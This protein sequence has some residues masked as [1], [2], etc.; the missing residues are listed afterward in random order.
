M[1]CVSTDNE[2]QRIPPSV[3]GTQ[4]ILQEGALPLL[5]AAEAAGLHG[6]AK[7][8]LK[9]LLRASI[10]GRLESIKVSGRRLTSAE[11]IVRWV[12]AAQHRRDRFALPPTEADRV[13][14]AFDLGREAGSLAQPQGGA[15][16]S[17]SRTPLSRVTSVRDSSHQPTSNQ[18]ET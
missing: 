5:D 2:S 9:T 8:S 12:E 4:R 7:P 18:K 10:C 15:D 1:S 11:A 14:E 17:E 13:L 3:T 6:A 16:E